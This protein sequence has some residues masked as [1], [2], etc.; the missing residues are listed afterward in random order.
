MYY[1]DAC[2]SAEHHHSR[3]HLQGHQEPPWI[4]PHPRT[5]QGANPGWFN[6][7][8]IFS[9][10]LFFASF[11]WLL[12]SRSVSL[13]V[14]ECFSRPKATRL[15]WVDDGW[16]CHCKWRSMHVNFLSILWLHKTLLMFN[17]PLSIREKKGRY[18]SLRRKWKNSSQRINQ[19]VWFWNGWSTLSAPRRLDSFRFLSIKSTW[20]FLNITVE[21]C[22]PTVGQNLEQA[23]QLKEKHEEDMTV[24]GYVALMSLCCRH[25]NVDE[26]LNLKREMWVKQ[27]R[28]QLY[29][30][31][32]DTTERSSLCVSET[33][34]FITCWC[35]LFLITSYIKLS[36]KRIFYTSEVELML[37][38]RS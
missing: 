5:H 25:N 1:D 35:F 38:F 18:R 4:L 30:I 26:A 15:E 32:R 17:E 24:G 23:L 33:H 10:F 22:C 9:F 2:F 28:W 7:E 11:K 3:K 12:K 16:C 20:C 6:W 27:E 37:R 34:L 13:S 14:R 21:S 31:M 36:V 29:L 19:S 8:S